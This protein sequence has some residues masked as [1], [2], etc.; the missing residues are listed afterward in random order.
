MS[1]LLQQGSCQSHSQFPQPI[2]WVQTQ[3]ME[4]NQLA[5]VEVL[6]D[7][8]RP[9]LLNEEKLPQK[10][11]LL[12]FNPALYFGN[13][14]IPIKY[15]LPKAFN[16][17]YDLFSVYQADDIQEE[18]H[19]WNVERDNQAV[20]VMTTHRMADLAE[21]RYMNFS[22]KQHGVPE[23]SHYFQAGSIRTGT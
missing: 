1:W 9:I 8:S 17:K 21:L 6:T 16:G 11:R 10:E 2:L 4:G 5:W 18:C 22:S 12:N 7:H 20:Q 13:T 15:P 23:L 14:E 3:V 19:L